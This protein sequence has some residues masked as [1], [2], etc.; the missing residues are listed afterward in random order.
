MSSY[1]QSTTDE[2]SDRRGDTYETET[3]TYDSYGQ[4]PPP[5]VPPPWIARWDE[6]DQ[7][8]FFINERTGERTFDFP[9]AYGGGGGYERD[10]YYQQ[11]AQTEYVE[12]RR[13]GHGGRNALL[14]GGA[15]LIGGAALM[16]E[17]EKVRMWYDQ[18]LDIFERAKM[19]LYR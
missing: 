2:Y 6:R 12:E 14:A 19:C 1:Y 8:Y 9:Q 11:P 13:E 10:T 5:Q 17:G 18:P 15:G 4:P 7:R 16:Y 3:T